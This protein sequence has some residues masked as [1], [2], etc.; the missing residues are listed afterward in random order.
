MCQALKTTQGVLLQEV[1][2]AKHACNSMA[3]PSVV[4][5]TKG[6]SARTHSEKQEA[7]L[8]RKVKSQ[9]RSGMSAGQSSTALNIA[10]SFESNI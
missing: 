8:Q 1:E 5:G 9:V 7:H 4:M 6:H 3:I 2:K 10:F